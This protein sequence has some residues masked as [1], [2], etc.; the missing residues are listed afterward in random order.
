MHE[1]G[2][3][4][5]RAGAQPAQPQWNIFHRF[6][7]R[8]APP[9]SAYR[10]TPKAT[11]MPFC[12]GLIDAGPPTMSDRPSEA[13]QR[14]AFPEDPTGQGPPPTGSPAFGP[15]AW[16]SAHHFN[17]RQRRP[18]GQEIL[19]DRSRRRQVLTKKFSRRRLPTESPPA[20]QAPCE[21]A[22]RP[23]AASAQSSLP[24]TR[25]SPSTI[26]PCRGSWHARPSDVQG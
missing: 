13:G 24:S 12:H 15:P 19:Q 25:R 10:K 4:W 1:E 9:Q 14:A 23:R 16:A 7:H 3:L 21:A 18:A 11:E 17:P 5:K 22:L 2:C 6:A 8:P 20:F 26:R